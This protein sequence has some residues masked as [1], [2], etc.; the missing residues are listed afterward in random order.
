MSESFAKK[1]PQEW[2]REWQRAYPELEKL[3]ATTW[4]P[5]PITKEQFHERLS[6]FMAAKRLKE[7]TLKWRSVRSAAL[8]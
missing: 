5:T 2:L 3:E 4:D 6:F 8:R 7:R 1:A